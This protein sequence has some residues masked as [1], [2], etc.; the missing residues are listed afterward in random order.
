[1]HKLF[2]G[3]QFHFEAV[4]VLGM[5]PTGGAEVGECLAAIGAIRDNDGESVSPTMKVLVE[6]TALEQRLN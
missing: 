4:R 5:A 6:C 2:S 1:M 3:V